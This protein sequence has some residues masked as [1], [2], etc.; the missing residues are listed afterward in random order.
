MLKT[1]ILS[2][3]LHTEISTYPHLIQMTPKASPRRIHLCLCHMSGN[4]QRYIDE[5]FADNWVVPLG[6][7][8]DA[9]ENSLQDFLSKGDPSR[10]HLRIAAVSAGTAA[11][12]L[13]LILAG[14]KAGDEVICQSFTFAASANPV[15]YQGAT[16]VFVDS[17]A[18]TWN[19]DP[20][21]LDFAISDRIAKTGRKPSAIIPVHLYGMPAK[22]DEIMMIADKW[23]IPV[24]EDAAEALGSSYRGHACG[25]FG[26]FGALSFNGNKMITT[27]GGG[28]L[29]CPDQESRARAVF[30][31]TQARESYP[32]Y[33]HENIGYNY[34]MSNIC[35]GIGRGQMTVLDEHI[36]HHCR[37]AALYASLLA[38]VE[39]VDFHANPS[40]ESDANFWLSTIT[41]DPSLTG[42]LTPDELRLHFESLNIETRLLW[43]PMHMQPVFSKAPAYTNGV[44]SSLF[45]RGL[46]LPSGPW[47]TEEDVEMIVSEIKRLASR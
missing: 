34:R 36:A 23:D 5:A 16:P 44:S 31:A 41:I 39:G 30:F 28:A 4:E 35:A 45:S 46:C 15:T 32:Y 8:V 6:P 25:T 2:V 22:M 19:M 40:P 14:V 29:V 47:V 17:E 3:S 21:L 20:A 37:L 10:D 38:D 13:G 26:N 11:I 7:N 24:V 9:F 1:I 33:Q 18:D 42:G 27:S 43:K 12:H